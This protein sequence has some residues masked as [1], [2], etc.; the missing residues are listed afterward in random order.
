L[1]RSGWLR[2]AV[3]VVASVVLTG[4]LAGPVAALNAR[5]AAAWWWWPSPS[6]IPSPTPTV[7]LSLDATPTPTPDPTVT[8][9]PSTGTPAPTG[10]PT[11]TPAAAPSPTPTPTATPTPTPTPTT[12]PTRTALPAPG[13]EVAVLSSQTI[14]IT[15]LKSITVRTVTRAS[16]QVKV[17]ELQAAAS[18][19]TGLNL[20]G[21]C[22]GRSQVLTTADQENASGGLTIDATA[23]QATILG[24]P[25]VLA[26]ADLPDGA[27]TLPGISLPPLPADLAIVSVKLFTLSITSGAMSFSGLRIVNQAC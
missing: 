8:P 1:R 15:A 12:A 17:I 13:P 22:S 10:T 5:D 11:P 3:L 25:I 26:A 7:A 27:V 18:T 16:G 14:S 9:T 24:V 23:L 2:Y 20:Q 4:I 21:P 19:I 6:P